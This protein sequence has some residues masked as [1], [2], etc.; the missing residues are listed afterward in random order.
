NRGG[1][2]V[3]RGVGKAQ[4]LSFVVE[5]SDGG[6]RA[7]DLLLVRPAFGTKALD[8][9]RRDEPAV[10]AAARGTNGLPSR[11]DASALVTRRR[12]R[13]QHLAIVRLRD[14]RSLIGS[15]IERI[16]HPK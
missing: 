15:R 6:D 4:S 1:Q 12:Q 3:A 8:E 2:T 16:A 5:R 7:E 13:G 14:Q 9:R 10:L 11:E